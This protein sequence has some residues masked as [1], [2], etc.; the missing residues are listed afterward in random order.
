MA[1][2]T[3]EL[4][5]RGQVTI[6]KSLREQYNWETGQQFSIIDLG[7]VVVMSPRTSKVVALANQLRDDLIKDGATLEDMLA[8]LRRIREGKI[9]L[10]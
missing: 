10:S 9:D 3:I 4:A 5:Q 2:H 8:E 6:P 7:G 1:S